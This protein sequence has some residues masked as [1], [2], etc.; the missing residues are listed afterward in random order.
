MA[1]MI[2]P[3]KLASDSP[4][5]QLLYELSRLGVTTQ[6]DF[7]AR[8]DR[9][10]HEREILH[11]EALTLAAAEHDRVREGAVAVQKQLQLEIEAERKRR[12][13]EEQRTLETLRQEKADR[14][15][16]ERRRA[17]EQAKIDEANEKRLAEAREAA[18]VAQRKKAQTEQHNAE[19]ARRSKEAQDA[20]EVKRRQVEDEAKRKAAET[21]S[22][23]REIA[24]GP[25]NGLA[26][27]TAAQPTKRAPSHTNLDP[28]RLAEHQRYMEI[29]RKLKELRKG[30]LDQVK[31]NPAMKEIMGNVRRAIKQSVG[32]LTMG[33]GV[34]KV[35]VGYFM[36]TPIHLLIVPNSYTKS[37]QG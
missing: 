34:N 31:Q 23:T 22:N 32:Q 1:T 17:I 36:S 6:E 10:N 27:P 29:H 18:A 15:I 16:A 24:V 20:A 7:Y 37:R 3:Y 12:H 33:K 2:S 8:L 4:S 28:G 35:P 14:E 9:E 11:K 25:Q 5:R 19:A 21:S 13:E 30:M 26:V